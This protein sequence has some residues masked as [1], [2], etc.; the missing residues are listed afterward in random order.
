MT[1]ARA[2]LAV[3]LAAV[4]PYASTLN[5]YFV[6]DDFGVVWLLSHKPWSSFPAWFVSTWMDDIWGYTPDEIRPFPALTYQLASLG[7]AS[8]PVINHLMNVALHAAN[9]LLALAVARVVAGLELTTATL[10]ALLFVVL[11][12]QAES[13]AW[14][15]G[16]VDSMPAF[17]YMTA[18]LLYVLWRQREGSKLYWASVA[19]FFI[20]LFTKQN[21]ITLG[22]ALVLYDVLLARRPLRV[23]WDWLRPFLP[24]IVLTL[25]YLALRYVLFGEVARESQLTESNLEYFAS[26]LV[27][28]VRRMVFGAVSHGSPLLAAVAGLLVAALLWAAPRVTTF[29]LMWWV[30]CVAPV[31]VAAYESPRHIYLASVAWAILLGCAVQLVP[32]V[33]P[34]RTLAWAGAASLLVIYTLQLTRVIAEWE[35]RALVS[36]AAVRDLGREVLRA[37]E[38]AL[39]VADAPVSS[40]EWALPFVLRKPFAETDLEGRV[41]VVS[42]QLLHCCRSQWEE[43]TRQEIRAWLSRPERPPVVA[44]R[45]DPASGELFRLS[46]RDEPYLRSLMEVLVETDSAAALNRGIHD[47]TNHL[48]KAPGHSSIP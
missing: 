5:D 35:T 10:A 1:P 39:I 13:V 44:L 12:I 36:Q 32:R 2:A 8:S 47:L 40:W 16:R 4:V 34:L 21:A 20:A 31:V 24:F 25:G 3:C 27:R 48:P 41:T 43:F 23:S 29:F 7:G 37:A 17:F 28:H 38:G 11:P 15:T 14:V 19:A 6:Q 30:L 33:R 42:P 18:F 26:L 9:G 22:P 45:W 46:E